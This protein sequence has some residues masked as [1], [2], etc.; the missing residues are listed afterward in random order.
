LLNH[1]DIVV[2]PCWYCC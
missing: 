2:K 1:V